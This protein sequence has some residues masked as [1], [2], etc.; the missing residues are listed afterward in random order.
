MKRSAFSITLFI[1]GIIAF[2]IV[3]CAFILKVES[4]AFGYAVAMGV[5]LILSILLLIAY[6]TVLFGGADY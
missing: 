3:L 4:L 6:S 5:L 2:I 1:L